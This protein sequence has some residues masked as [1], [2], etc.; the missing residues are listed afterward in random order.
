[1]GLQGSVFG[2]WLRNC[3]ITNAGALIF[4][5]GLGVY[6]AIIKK[7]RNPRNPILIIKAS[8]VY[9]SEVCL[10]NGRLTVTRNL[11]LRGVRKYEQ[12]GSGSTSKALGP[13]HHTA[14]L[15]GFFPI[16]YPKIGDPNIVP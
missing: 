15:F 9:A 11:E 16:D 7:I 3:E 10:H 5:I 1:M 14:S 12:S 4:R 2:A 13:K 8:T 6:Y